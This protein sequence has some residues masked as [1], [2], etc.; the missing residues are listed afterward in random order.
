MAQSYVLNPEYIEAQKIVA[1]HS[2]NFFW[3][4]DA[5]D[6]L[7]EILYG[8]KELPFKTKKK[9]AERLRTSLYGEV[10][11]YRNYKGDD[12]RDLIDYYDVRPWLVGA[13][14][15]NP[16]LKCRAVRLFLVRSQTSRPLKL[17]FIGMIIENKRIFTPSVMKGIFD[18]YNWTGHEMFDIRP[19]IEAIRE[20]YSLPD[21]IP[22]SWVTKMFTNAEV[23]IP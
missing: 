2:S 5:E 21:S 18:A 23:K 4:L 20:E 19:V 15:S 6:E 16:N 1:G 12:L 22:D 9:A 10:W 11:R 14:A 3:K 7:L 17:R 13:F 8:D